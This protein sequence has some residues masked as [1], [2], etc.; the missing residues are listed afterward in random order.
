[1]VT[2]KVAVYKGNKFLLNQNYI[3]VAQAFDQETQETRLLVANS[4]QSTYEFKEIDLSFKQFKEHSY[5]F[6]DSSEN[7]VFL[8]VNHFGDKSTYGHLYISDVEGVKYST[9]LQYNVRVDETQAE[10]EKVK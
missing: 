7:S 4:T 10:F 2:S 8:H 3:F 6:L 1:M 9:S 5:S